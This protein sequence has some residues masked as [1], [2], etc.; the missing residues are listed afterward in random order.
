MR[1]F[2]DMTAHS[3]PPVDLF[4]GFEGVTAESRLNARRAPQD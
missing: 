2:V 4:A 1:L 3:K